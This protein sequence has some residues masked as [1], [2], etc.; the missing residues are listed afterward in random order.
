ML[1]NLIGWKVSSVVTVSPTK[2]PASATTHGSTSTAASAPVARVRH[3]PNGRHTRS[4]GASRA[5]CCLLAQARARGSTAHHAEP[6]RTSTAHQTMSGGEHRLGPG[7]VDLGQGAGRQHEHRRDRGGA[8]DPAAGE[9]PQPG[10]E[11]E[12]PEQH[13]P[14]HVTGEPPARRGEHGHPRQVR[15]EVLHAGGVGPLLGVDVLA[16]PQ[17]VGPL[18]QHHPHVDPGRRVAEDRDGGQGDVGGHREPVCR[19]GRDALGAGQQH[20][21][22]EAPDRQHG[23]CRGQPPAAHVAEQWHGEGEGHRRDDHR[24]SQPA[25]HRD[26]EAARQPPAE[27]GR[28]RRQGEHDGH[29]EAHDAPLQHAEPGEPGQPEDD[30]GERPG[31]RASGPGP[32]GS[33]CGGCRRRRRQPP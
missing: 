27:Q 25:R 26:L 10:E 23:Q 30:G 24:R 19:G 5:R 9:G 7:L 22:A 11:H 16:A 3:A 4:T 29:A 2:A 13:G 18:L 28:A 33:G 6:R 17:G 1:A 21:A 20:G 14:A 31:R 32:R 8:L 15:E 12:R